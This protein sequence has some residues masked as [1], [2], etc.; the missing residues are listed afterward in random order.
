MFTTLAASATLASVDFGSTVTGGTRTV[1]T[2][3]LKL[4]GFLIFLLVGY[5]IAKVIAKVL[6][7]VLEKVGFEEAVE[8]APAKQALSKS[9]DEIALPVP[10]HGPVSDLG[11][12]LADRD[13]V[14]DLA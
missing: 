14:R 7:K 11:G 13:H 10:G 3:V 8:K 9:R 6:D 12:A 2:F 5:F 4:I 1:T